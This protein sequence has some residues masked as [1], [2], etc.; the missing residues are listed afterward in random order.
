MTRETGEELVDVPEPLI[1]SLG[2]ALLVDWNTA[3][4][5]HQLV[6]ELGDG[7]EL[8]PTGG[9]PGTGTVDWVLNCQLVV[10]HW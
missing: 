4:L 7:L 2:T 3:D 8:L 5:L 9:A 10:F 1:Q 6:D